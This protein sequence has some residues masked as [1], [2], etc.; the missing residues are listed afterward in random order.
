VDAGAQR[1]AD[2]ALDLQRAP[3]LLAAGGLAVGAGVGGARQH[4]VLRGHP[5]RTLAA[6]D[7]RHAVLH[8]G[9]AQHA[10]LS[11]GHEHR[12]LGV[13][14]VAALE[15]RLAHLAG[16]AAAGT[17]GLGHVDYR[18][19]GARVYHRHPEPPDAG[20]IRSM[21]AYASGERSTPWGTLACEL[22]AV[23]HRFLEIGVRAPDELRALEPQLRERISAR[24]SRGKVDVS[25]R[26]RPAEGVATLHVDQALLSQLSELAVDAA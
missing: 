22:R 19:N 20:M 8:A 26:L 6:Q 21:T 2:Q 13:A 17:G 16:C 10:G 1:T 23:N 7:A 25:L 11:G 12:P 3:A 9:G 4:A 15:R 24:V 18:W 14:G 5:A